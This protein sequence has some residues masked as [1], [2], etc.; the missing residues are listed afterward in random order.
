MFAR[1]LKVGA[2]CGI[3][4]YAAHSAHEYAYKWNIDRI[5]KEFPDLNKKARMWPDS[6]PEDLELTERINQAVACIEA[7]TPN[8]NPCY[9]KGTAEY[10]RCSA[11]SRFA[12]D[13]AFESGMHVQLL[14]QHHHTQTLA[15][16]LR[17]LHADKT[18]FRPVSV[19][20]NAARYGTVSVNDEDALCRAVKACC[21]Q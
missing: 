7:A 16:I 17:M 5:E 2:A 1:V 20:A 18:V 8:P 19:M 11:M 3:T 4:A 15:C 9:Y 21:I 10:R 14:A 13:I 6:L 12:P